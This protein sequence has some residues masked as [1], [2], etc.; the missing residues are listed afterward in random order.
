MPILLLKPFTHCPLASLITPPQKA[1][2]LPPFTEPSVFSFNYPLSDF[3]QQILLITF[4]TEALGVAPQWMNSQAW[5]RISP[6][7]FGFLL[8]LL[9]TKLFLLFQIFHTA[10]GKINHQGGLVASKLQLFL[11]LI[12]NHT[13]KSLL[14]K[15]WFE[16]VIPNWFHTCLICG[17]SRRACKMVSKPLRQIV[18]VLSWTTPL[19]QDTPWPEYCY[20]HTSI[21]WFWFSEEC[22]LSTAIWLTKEVHPWYP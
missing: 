6:A 21:R 15:A 17:Q 3:T 14:Q 19:F 9:K 12:D 20:E 10:K 2:P 1:K 16:G 13:C 4:C 7:N 8:L 18:H 22:Q 5:F 11:S